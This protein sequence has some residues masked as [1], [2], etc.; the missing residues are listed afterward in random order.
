MEVAA[1]EPAKPDHVPDEL[2]W[3]HSFK[4]F[5]A[6]LD[7]PYIAGARLHDGP[8][9]IWAREA[10]VRKPGWIVPQHALI[11]EIQLDHEH[12]SSTRGSTVDAILGS[13]FRLIPLEIDPLEH[14]AY[15]H[16]LNPCFTPKAVNAI[17]GKIRDDCDKLIA[18]FE[19]RGNCE[20]ISEFAQIFPNSIV[21]HLMGMPQEMLPQFLKWEETMLRG[22][23]DQ[24]HL[25]A[26]GEVLRYFGGFIAFQKSNPGTDLMRAIINGKINGKQISD[27]DILGICFVLYLGGLDTV[28]NSMGWI[29]RHLANDQELQRRLRENLDDIPKAIDEFTHASWGCFASS[30]CGQ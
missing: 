1:I 17:E 10:S 21:L 16:L 20:F 19:D 25:A 15:R 6:E 30:H 18:R 29:M 3:D 2:Y 22:G 4:D 27:A 5:L 13:A 9:I 12:F 24:A 8:G 28:Y 23:D 26:V 7:D 14:H 11:Q